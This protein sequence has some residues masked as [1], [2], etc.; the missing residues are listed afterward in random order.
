M[1]RFAHAA[2]ASGRLLSSGAAGT[3]ALRA[4]AASFQFS[5]FVF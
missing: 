2:Q 1:M 5:F 3:A 4:A